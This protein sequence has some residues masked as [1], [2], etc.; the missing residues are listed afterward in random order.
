[1]KGE[2]YSNTT[3]QIQLSNGRKVCREYDTYH[4]RIKHPSKVF[5][6]RVLVKACSA[7][8]QYVALFWLHLR[9]LP[10][11]VQVEMIS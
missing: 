8:R 9:W 1:M 11:A 2:S 10:C 3:S 7:A 5:V 6:A 4:V